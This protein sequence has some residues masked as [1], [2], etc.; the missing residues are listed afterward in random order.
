MALELIKNMHEQDKVDGSFL[1]LLRVTLGLAFLTTWFSNLTKGAFTASGFVST[2]EYFITD[3]AHINIGFPLNIIVTPFDDIIQNVAFPNA[4]IFGMGWLFIE[5]FIS[6]SLTFGLF[7]RLGSI[8]GAGSTIVL[9]IGAL[10]VDWP[11][12][13]ALMFIGFVTCALTS[14]GKWYGLDY[15]LKDRIPEKLLMI[16]I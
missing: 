16:L 14:A 6:I 5:L 13:Y 15:W 3:P 4:A 9:G 1:A 12:T 8:F 11:W 7:T 2:I 10:G